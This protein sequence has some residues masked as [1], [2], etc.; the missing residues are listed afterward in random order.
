MREVSLSKSYSKLFSVKGCK[1]RVF[2]AVLVLVLMFILESICTATSTQNIFFYKLKREIFSPYIQTYGIVVP[3]EVK[4]VVETPGKLIFTVPEGT[5]FKKG[6]LIAKVDT[7]TLQKKLEALRF[8]RK[9]LESNF[10]Y[11][12]RELKRAEKLFKKKVIAKSDYEKILYQFQATQAQLDAIAKQIEELEITIRKGSLF[13]PFDGFVLKK[14]LQTYDFA[15]SP[16]YILAKD[17]AKFN[18]WVPVD[19]L[20]YFKKAVAVKTE[21]F[22]IKLAHTTVESSFRP[23]PYTGQ[24]SILCPVDSKYIGKSYKTYILLPTTEVIRVPLGAVLMVKDKMFV[25]K[26]EGDKYIRQ[27][28]EPWFVYEDSVLVKRGI[29]EGDEILRVG[30]YSTT[31][32][33]TVYL[34]RKK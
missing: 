10:E 32:D 24:I 27:E 22:V 29:S 5:H 4:A 21:D 26:K 20:E 2:L 16:V 34:D 15:K 33:K 6:E 3:D 1:R 9:S 14:L 28:I 7:S 23:I 19:K 17:K 13:A 30:I 8:Q 18:F 25:L 31:F 12:T 11:L